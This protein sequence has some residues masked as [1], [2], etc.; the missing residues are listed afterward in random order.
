MPEWLKEWWPLIVFSTPFIYGAISWVINKGL[1]S[2]DE[3]EAAIA[4]SEG[5]AEKK[6]KEI[7]MRLD[8]GAE[9]F[10][11]LSKQVADTPSKT[12]FYEVLLALQKQD[13]KI[14]VV[15]ER[16]EGQTALMRRVEEVV[17]RHENIFSDAARK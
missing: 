5:E 14:D 2:K 4:K 15:S 6:L 12:E 10:E 9:R 11:H 7:R 13:G 3:L 1:V 16:I 8:D 17:T